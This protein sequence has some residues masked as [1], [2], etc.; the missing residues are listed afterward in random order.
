MN[1]VVGEVLKGTLLPGLGA[2]LLT[3]GVAL[4]RE[5]VRHLRDARLRRV[6]LSLVQAAEQIY[7]AGK[8]EAK[9]RYVR[10]KMKE[11]SLPL[12]RE[13]IEA[14]VYGVTQDTAR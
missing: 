13:D 1:E 5:Y 4:V 9:R 8:G 10:E 6:L 14:T 12:T 7:G 3:A 11:K 2:I